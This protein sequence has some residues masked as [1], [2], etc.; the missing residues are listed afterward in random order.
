MWIK[1]LRSKIHRGRVTATRL[2]YE[3]S[4][5]IDA[6][7]ME[8]AGLVDGEIALVANLANG[9]RHETYVIPAERGSGTISV[10][11]A[12][13]RLAAPGDRVIIMGFALLAPEELAD[14]SP[15]KIV[16]DERNRIVKGP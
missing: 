2:D 10:Q 8:A 12:A 6:D 13:A 15:R 7:L 5:G 16:L 14:H 4:I 11:G 9:T 3:G 1:V